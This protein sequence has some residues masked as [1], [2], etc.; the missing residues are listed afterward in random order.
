MI[1]AVGNDVMSIAVCGF[2]CQNV[3]IE[4]SNFGIDT[5]PMS[6]D[7]NYIDIININSKQDFYGLYER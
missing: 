6:Y 5:P 3:S 2:C 1:R 4:I 7:Y